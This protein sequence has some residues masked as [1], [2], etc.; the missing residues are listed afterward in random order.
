MKYVII[1][2]LL[3]GWNRTNYFIHVIISSLCSSKS[4]SR[5]LFIKGNAINERNPPSC[6]VPVTAFF[7]EE[8]TGCIKE[9]P[10][11]AIN[12]AAIGTI[13]SPRNSPSSFLFHF[14]LF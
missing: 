7:Y 13:I 5:T 4:S 1:L 14:F 11:G 12:E 2:T 6:L 10:I 8:A 9:E 3:K